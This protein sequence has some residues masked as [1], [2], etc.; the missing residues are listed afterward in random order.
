M[1]LSGVYDVR[2]LAGGGHN[3]GGLSRVYDLGGLSGL[4]SYWNYP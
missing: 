1:G 4:T 2:G 3:V